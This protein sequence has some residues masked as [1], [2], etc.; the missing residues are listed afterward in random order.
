M[1]LET[2]L[3]ETKKAY[4]M[5]LVAGV[6]GIKQ[7]I[8]WFHILEDSA[9]SSFI[10]GNELVFTAGI[11]YQGE[12]WLVDFV[13]KLYEHKASGMVVNIGP[14]IPQIPQQVISF[15]DQHGFPLF[16]VPWKIKLVDVTRYLSQLILDSERTLVQSVAA[17]NNLITSPIVLDSYKTQ[18][19][20]VGYELDA[21]YCVAVMPISKNMRNP[22]EVIHRAQHVLLLSDEESIVFRLNKNIVFVF[23]AS[24]RE[25]IYSAVD[26][27]HLTLAQTFPSIP[28]FMGVSGNLQ[29]IDTLYNSYQQANWALSL[30]RAEARD[31]LFYE[32]TGLYRL[33]FPIQNRQILQGFADEVL[34]EII[35]YDKAHKTDY[36]E[37]LKLYMNCDGSV[38][39]VVEKAYC[40]RNT[41]NHK[42]KRIKDLFQLEISSNEQ[43][44]RIIMAFHILTLLKIQEN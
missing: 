5:E 6:A 12:A 11:A 30:A 13:K 33:L 16:T 37:W 21:K 31:Y 28:F 17:L 43:K 27:L 15:C 8:S 24:T 44:V 4:S 38:Q 14:F 42:L 2:V 18:I 20:E 25:R 22:E 34:G 32:E 3:N 9:M 40:H 10:H 36:L 35:N 39:R 23:I 1:I 7:Q 29:G 19:T 26:A 41:V